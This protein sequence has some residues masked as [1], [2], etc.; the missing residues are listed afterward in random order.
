[1]GTNS[2]LIIVLSIRAGA[3][4]QGDESA[5]VTTRFRPPCRRSEIGMLTTIV[6]PSRLNLGRP[7]ELMEIG[8]RRVIRQPVAGLVAY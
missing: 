8:P 3:G 1:M 6:W 4:D 2:V 5:G 7:G